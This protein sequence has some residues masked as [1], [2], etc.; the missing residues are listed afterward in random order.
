M[1][2]LFDLDDFEETRTE[3]VPLGWNDGML[4]GLCGRKT[5]MNQGGSDVGPV[6]DAC[7]AIDRC[8]LRCCT[9][10]VERRPSMFGHEREESAHCD[11]CGWFLLLERWTDDGE[12][13]Q[14]TPEE[15]TD[16]L[17]QHAEPRHVTHWGM[18]HPP[19]Q[20]DA[21]V[22]AQAKRRAA[23]LAKAVIA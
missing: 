20:H 4:C 21:L 13:K 6:C 22:K 10:V 19:A 15:L 16:L 17:A 12:L 14:Y 11:D 9:P 5:T 8:R 3:W 2:L 7:A 23:Y 1:T 18:T